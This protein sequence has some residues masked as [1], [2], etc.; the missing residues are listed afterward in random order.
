MC[1][2]AA[3]NMQKADRKTCDARGNGSAPDCFPTF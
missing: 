2:S 3:D 1:R